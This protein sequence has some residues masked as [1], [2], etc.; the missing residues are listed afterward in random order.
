MLNFAIGP[1][2]MDDEI[3]QI[4]ANQ[5]PYFRTD[6]FSQI[7]K[8]N[9]LYIK[10]CMSA[11]DNSRALFLTGSGT[12]AMEAAVQNLFT[13]QDKLLVINGGS[14]GKRFAK[15]CSIHQIPHTELLL[16]T[17]AP[18]T[19]KDLLP[20]YNQG[21]TGFLINILETST[22]VHYDLDLVSR[23]CKENGCLLVVDAVSSFLADPLY[24][25]RQGVDVVLT[26]SQKGLALPPGISI[27]VLNERSLARVEHNQIESLYFDLKEYLKDGERGQTPFTPAVSILIQL[28][29]RLEEVMQ[30]GIDAEWKRIR[31]VAED[32]RSGL[33]YHKLPFAIATTALSNAVT[34]LHPLNVSAYQ[35]F[36]VLK[37]EYDVFVCPNG[38]DLKNTLFRVGHLGNLTT[39]DNQVLLTALKDMESRG[40]L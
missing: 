30:K 11:S 12:A 16:A 37:D 13:K 38:G 20:Y 33:V 8:T 19:E 27:L 36:S 40:L 34:P 7:M 31:E 2:Q 6:E 9:E 32:F 28:E 23:F 14:F 29:K 15:I 5:I 17:G 18:L 22:G 1:V 35:I 21:Y 26:G 3:L 39:K 4:G 24:M 25:E 10:K